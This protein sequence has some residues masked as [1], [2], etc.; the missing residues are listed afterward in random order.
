MSDPRRLLEGGGDDLAATLLRAAQDD[1]P[2]EGSKKRAAAALGL[3]GTAGI[4]AASGGTAG[5]AAAAK[6]VSA[7]LATKWIGVGIAG[8]VM[9]SAASTYR[10][11][12]VQ[13]ALP[14]PASVVTVATAATAIA[15]APVI[16]TA[17]PAATPTAADS[18]ALAATPPPVATPAP[19]VAPPPAHAIGRE[20]ALLDGART[21]LA[22]GDPGDALHRLDAYARV[23]PEGA[24]ALEAS[25][26]RVEALH[27]R[28]DDARASSLAR[29]ILLR[30]PDAPQAAHLR[31]ILREVQSA[32]D[33]S[34]P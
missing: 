13:P 1:A 4:G 23:F 2:T 25:V 28:G 33:P 12:A 26:V 3:T 32:T 8:V 19:V 31:T 22:A 15:S 11:K 16:G 29:Q 24:L 6:A 34:N 20:V 9:A 30:H 7:G 18:G 10:A 21:S 5:T 14:T 17:R 27:A